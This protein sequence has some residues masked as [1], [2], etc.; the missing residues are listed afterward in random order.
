MLR[1][2][3]FKSDEDGNV[4]MMFSATIVLLLTGIGV[5]VD[6]SG[7]TR[8]RTALQAQVD[9]GVLAA[10]TVEID[11][12]NN[13]NGNAFGNEEQER[14]IRV[15]AAK[16][17]ISANGF[18]LQGIEPVLT[19]Q[20]SSVVL[21]AELEYK[22]FFG[23]IL[24]FDKMRISADSESGLPKAQGVDIALVLDNTDSM[25]VDGKMDALKH[26][27]VRLVETIEGTG[28]E[29]K[30][31]IVPF[32]RYVRINE[33]LRTAS[34]F[35]MPTEFDTEVSWQ[36]AIRTGG[37]CTRETRTRTVD[38]V[39]EQYERN[40]CTGQTT[41]YED[42]TG[43]FESR[44]RGC[45][46]TRVPPFSETDDAYSHRV[47]GLL[48]QVPKEHTGT[49]R[50]IYTDCPAEI[51]PLTTEYDDLKTKING[52]WTTDNTYLPSGLIWGQRVLSPGEPFDNTTPAGETEKRKVM[53]ILTD[54]NNTTEIRQDADSEA[55]WEAPPYIAAVD[56]D[57]VAYEANAATV[58]MCQNAKSEGIEIFTIA[59]QVTDETTKDLLRNCA[60]SPENAVTAG[61]NS[62]LI[63]RFETLAEN[64][65]DEVRLMR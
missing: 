34:W 57:E 56:N 6:Y 33:S 47:P 20:E 10:A 26:G 38:G 23:G 1:Y 32:S 41:T 61:T 4:A 62:G 39:E 55:A 64:L 22:P 51:V 44:W 58:R 19:L 17:V 49:S 14:E 40:V 65:K 46:G 8:A 60:S 3:K 45:V 13:G 59:F 11:I 16:E 42:R 29:S 9:A 53:I 21:K 18:D 35:E 36:Q 50:N 48:N 54:G 63:A 25:R 31:A 52:M 2:S 7:M 15:Q 28:S 12:E 24:G 5:A 43:T 37:S 30:I 27:A